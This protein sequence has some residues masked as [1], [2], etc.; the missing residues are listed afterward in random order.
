M[1]RVLAESCLD[2]LQ[3]CARPQKENKYHIKD[4]ITFKLYDQDTQS[5]GHNGTAVVFPFGY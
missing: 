2:P 3:E 1:S 4:L 5:G